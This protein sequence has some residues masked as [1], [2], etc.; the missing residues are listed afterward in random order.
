MF[1]AFQRVSSL[2]FGLLPAIV[3][4]TIAVVTPPSAQAQTAVA[5]QL[6]I[7]EFRLRGPNGEGC[8]WVRGSV[9]AHR[10]RKI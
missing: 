10:V 5:G 6:I 2:A 3:L 7:S 8:R 1:N 4:L 9:S